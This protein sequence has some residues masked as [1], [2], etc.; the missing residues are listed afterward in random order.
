VGDEEVLVVKRGTEVYAIDMI[1][2][3]IG[4]RPSTAL[5]EQAHLAVNR[6]I[7]VND[8]MEQ[9]RAGAAPAAAE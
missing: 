7:T 9:A 5:A 4:V 3:G 6:G 1:V 8:E 2:V